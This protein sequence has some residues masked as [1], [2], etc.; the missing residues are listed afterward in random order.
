MKK[1]YALLLLCFFV[2]NGKAQCPITI[3]GNTVICS[4]DNTTLSANSSATS[5]TWN[6]GGLSNFSV[7]V[8]PTVTT[9]YTVIGTDGVC[10]DSATVTISVNPEPT[11]GVSANPPTICAGYTTTLIATGAITYTWNIGVTGAITSTFPLYN[12]TNFTVTGISA[13]GCVGTNT[14]NVVVNPQPAVSITITPTSCGLCNGTATVI[15][16]GGIGPYTYSWNTFP[17]QTTTTI[18][19]SCYNN[20]TCSVQ[21]AL[22]CYAD[23]V[24]YFPPSTAISNVFTTLI[25]AACGQND[26]SITI[27]S[28]LGGVP[29]YTYNLN[30]NA[31][32]SNT[33]FSNLSAGTY[34]IG[35]Q[36]AVGCSNTFYSV[37][38]N[39]NFTVLSNPNPPGCNLCNGSISTSMIGGS[40][41]YTYAWSNG[42]NAPNPNN[43]CAGNYQVS[44]TD[45]SGCFTS[46]TLHLISPA[47]PVIN[48][49]T[50]INVPCVG[51]STGGITV[52]A[53]GGV[54]PYT[55]SWNTTPAQTDSA[56][57]GLQRGMYMITVTDNIGCSVSRNI[58]LSNS[59]NI[60]VYPTIVNQTNCGTN[61]SASIGASGGLAP[62]TF[63]WSN[64]AVGQTANNLIAG[65]Y[66]VT[67]T[68]AN[69]CIGTGYVNI[70]TQCMN[71]IRGRVYN[72]SNQNCVQDAGEIGLANQ[73]ITV[74]PGNYYGTT[75]VNGDYFVMT[76]SMTNTVIVSSNLSYE[77]PTCPIT[78][79]LTANFSVLGDTSNNNNF[80]YLANPNYVDLS[81]HP[82]WS[83][84]SPG[85]TKTYWFLHWNKSYNPVNAVVVM[86]YDARLQYTGC[87]NG[88][89]P[90]LAQHKIVWT[91]NN[92]PPTIYWYNYNWPIR[93]E[94]YF[95]VPVT[96]TLNDTL[97][98]H[99]EIQPLIDDYPSDNSYDYAECVTGSHDPNEKTVSPKGSGPNGNI[100]RSD[101]V[102]FYTIHFQNNGNDTAYR[103]V[104]VDT[105]S[106]FLDP[107]T[108]LPGAANHKY[109]FNLSG[110]G[111]CT[112]VFDSIMLPDS[113]TN[114]PES[115]G[116]LNF[117]VKQKPNNAFGSVVKNTANI[118]F[119]F[120]SAVITNTTK[121][122]ITAPVN[123]AEY[124]SNNNQ[125]LLY[126]NPTSDNFTLQYN[127][128][129]E[130]KVFIEIRN[131]LGEIV[132][133]IPLNNKQK[134]IHAEEINT[135]GFTNGIYLVKL[136]G[137]GMQ[138]TQKLIIQ[139]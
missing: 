26:G 127:L 82:G 111:V 31:Y 80:G 8:T 30:G 139:R 126:P 22:G 50:I 74:Y 118:Y 122:T 135:K 6:P 123:V 124:F 15:V 60:Y 45:S 62:Y 17:T 114:E 38:N 7:T 90:D 120:N 25:P 37:I 128:K 13:S 115:N 134:G 69:G 29:P 119:D 55:Y 75:D 86:V 47:A 103:V 91:Y 83:S 136:I 95:D 67:A 40:P 87:T 96:I 138:Q 94:A 105:L 104:V 10:T 102:L 18:S 121:N 36:D 12:S 20:Y 88:G 21:D 97:F 77:S 65:F 130:G 73:P 24:V 58:Y 28:V 4:G 9:T 129:N 61:G 46:N 72:D 112:W 93:P 100:L 89:V 16:S 133:T 76:P 92:L 49:D 64:S 32:T 19:N 63:T 116:Y 2:L 33:I 54:A 57:T 5:Y 53:S 117:T 81:I 66:T 14:I 52:S 109:T 71:F 85:S 131:M 51:L 3:T 78:G 84:S 48:I 108:I 113:L 42:T 56:A 79:S 59:N 35:V 23:N 99:F 101:S 110:K 27:D 34:T 70:P 1:I 106:P 132:K 98:T 39:S 68:D 41:P 107:A 11:I 43:L 125:L 137:E 44:V